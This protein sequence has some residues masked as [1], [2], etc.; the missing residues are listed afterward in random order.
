LSRIEAP[1]AVLLSPEQSFFLRE[2]FKLKLLN[3]RLGL[4]SRQVE[5]ARSDLASADMALKKYFDL[6]SR[7]TQNAALLLAQLQG[8][9]R[10]LQLPRIDETLAVLVTAVAGR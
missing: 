2:N 9:M 4:L 5:S 10:Q 6:R 8:Q 7:H 3:A 1:E